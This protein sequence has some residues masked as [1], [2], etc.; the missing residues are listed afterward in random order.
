MT[1]MRDEQDD[2]NI[3][4]TPQSLFHI[5]KHAVPTSTDFLSGAQKG[6]KKPNDPVRE[7][8]WHGFSAFDKLEGA[9]NQARRYRKLGDFIVEIAVAGVVGVQYEQSFGPGHYTVWAG[10]DTCAQSV[11]RMY[12]VWDTEEELI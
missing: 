10:P 8:Y 3:H 12:P 6:Q 11:V 2:T 4:S 1:G 7:R 5:I 9:R